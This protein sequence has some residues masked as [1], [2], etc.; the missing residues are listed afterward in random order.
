VTVRILDVVDGRI[1]ASIKQSNPSFDIPDI[2]AVDIGDVVHGAI[3]EIHADNA[4]LSLQPSNIRA[5]LSLKNIANNRNIP[6]SQLRTSLSVGEQLED[7]IVV[8]RNV[9]KGFV[10]V[11][12]KPKAKPNQLAKGNAITM[13]NVKVGQMIGGR[14]VRHTPQGALIKIT[15]HIGATLHLT[16]VTDDYSSEAAL[17]PVD[18]IMKAVVI[19]VDEDRRQLILSTRQSRMYPDKV[20]DIVDP[21]MESVENV[22]VGQQL[23][24]F[25]KNINDHGLFVTIGRGLDARVQIKELFDDVCISPA[26]LRVCSQFSIVCQGVERTFPAE[27]TCRR[28]YSEVSMVTPWGIQAQILYS[29]DPETK[30]IEMT[31]RSSQSKRSGGRIQID[32]LKAGQKV[33]GAIKRIEDYGMFIQIDNSKLNGLCHKSEV[34]NKGSN[35]R[36]DA[37]EDPSCLTIR[38]LTSQLPFKASASVTRSRHM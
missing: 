13:D 28:R 7:L 32:D 27:S 34:G 9:E 16:D 3:S 18:S 37:N 8:T 22:H 20:Q 17:P 33:D 12:N 30:R 31:F 35:L 4:I 23:R 19:H 24:G 26:A 14:V 29:I 15:A 1:V 11:A 5:I 6:L 2:S 21:E 10:I 38:M 25:I 36:Q